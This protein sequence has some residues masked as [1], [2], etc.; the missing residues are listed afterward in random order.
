MPR[1]LRSRGVGVGLNGHAPIEI[2]SGDAAVIER[3]PSMNVHDWRS[4]PAI[5]VRILH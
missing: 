1:C 2:A 4:V 5:S 3:H